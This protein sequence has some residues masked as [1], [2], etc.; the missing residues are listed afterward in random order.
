MIIKHEYF[1]DMISPFFDFK[2]VVVVVN[3][4]VVV[5]NIGFVVVV[6]NIVSILSQQPPNGQLGSIFLHKMI[7]EHGY[8][9]DMISPFFDFKIL[10]KSHFSN[11]PSSISIT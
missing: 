8:F 11:V 9:S 3:V 1:S 4:V 7:I 10:F 6:V 2:I 5:V